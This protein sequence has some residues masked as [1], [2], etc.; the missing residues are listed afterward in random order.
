[1]KIVISDTVGC[2]WS[3]WR[4]ALILPTCSPLKT[5]YEDADAG[6]KYEIDH[7]V[8]GIAEEESAIKNAD[9]CLIGREELAVE[10][11][12]GHGREC[13]RGCLTNAKHVQRPGPIIE[14]CI[15]VL[16]E[17]DCCHCRRTTSVVRQEPK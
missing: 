10:I 17:L 14:D 4:P 9:R 11:D 2:A 12:D 8:N 15:T 1:V 13:R 5:A 3:P 16:S 6:R 7:F